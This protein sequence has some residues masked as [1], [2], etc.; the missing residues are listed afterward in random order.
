MPPTAEE[1]DLSLLSEKELVN[2]LRRRLDG[3]LLITY[4]HTRDIGTDGNVYIFGSGTVV[5]G[6]LRS[7]DEAGEAWIV[8]S[9]SPPTDDEDAAA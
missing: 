6:L 1:I 3:L 8:N 9:E 7:M 2:E 5:R 4:E